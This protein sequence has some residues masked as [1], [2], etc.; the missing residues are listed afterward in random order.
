MMIFAPGGEGERYVE[1]IPISQPEQMETFMHAV[2]GPPGTSRETEEEEREIVELED[3]WRHDVDN[4]FANELFHQLGQ[5][6]VTHELSNISQ[7]CGR[8]SE[9]LS[10]LLS[11]EMKPVSVFPNPGDSS[12]E[13]CA[14]CDRLRQSSNLPEPL[15]MFREGSNLKIEGHSAPRLRLYAEP[16][17]PSPHASSIKY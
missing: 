16:G 4:V 13:G 6:E 7:L 5:L 9:N 2:A 10:S 15:Q 11:N 17:E 8:C 14:L 1:S 3:C 12:A